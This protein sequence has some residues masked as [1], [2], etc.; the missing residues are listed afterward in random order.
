MFSESSSALIIKLSLV[1]CLKAVESIAGCKYHAWRSFLLDEMMLEI[2]LVVKSK[3][4]TKSQLIIQEEDNSL[5][6]ILVPFLFYHN[7]T[8]VK[9]IVCSVPEAN[10]G[11]A[12][13]ES[14]LL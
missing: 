6:P 9:E 13:R 14:S 10:K 5:E 8:A 2:I 11:M 1:C 12:W 7:K 4:K 3:T